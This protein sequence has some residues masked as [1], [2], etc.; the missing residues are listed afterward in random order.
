MGYFDFEFNERAAVDAAHTLNR[1]YRG[2]RKFEMRAPDAAGTLVVWARS[3]EEAEEHLRNALFDLIFNRHRLG[4]FLETPACIYCGAKKVESR[5]RN[6]SGTQTWRCKNADC[7]RSFVLD[8]RFRGG[9]NH[10]SQSKKPEFVRLLRSGVTVREAADRLKL[11]RRT[12]VQWGMQ[13]AALHPE[14]FEGLECPCGKALRHRGSCAFRL[15]R[16][17]VAA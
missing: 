15:G 3:Q 9:I 1:A 4:R 11:N 13:L 10:P 8:R 7:Q 16:G 12:A 2:A 6:S 14:V 5:G 17:K